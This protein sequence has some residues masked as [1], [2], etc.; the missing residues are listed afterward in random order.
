MLKQLQ[1]KWVSFLGKVEQKFLAYC[2]SE[3]HF[4]VPSDPESCH[5]RCHQ[6]SSNHGP[7]QPW[8][9]GKK[10]YSSLLLSVVIFSTSYL[11]RLLKWL[12][13]S[14]WKCE[15]IS[16]DLVIPLSVD[17][18]PFLHNSTSQ[19]VK[20]RYSMQPVKNVFPP[21]LH[22]T[23]NHWIKGKKKNKRHK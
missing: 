13:S 15:C 1:V 17:C 6:I 11:I 12:R 21:S 5:N 14:A 20:W 7:I 8:G 3:Q 2:L 16:F 19:S 23:V 22:W 10:S 9:T 4:S 18:R